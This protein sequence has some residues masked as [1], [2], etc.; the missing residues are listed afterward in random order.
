MIAKWLLGL[1][2]I[3]EVL[4]CETVALGLLGFEGVGFEKQRLF[5]AT[6]RKRSRKVGVRVGIKPYV[7]LRFWS[8][9]H[10]CSRV[11]LY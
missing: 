1:V 3:V 7:R 11:T 6:L 10:Y 5:S 9:Q 8:S 4:G 2:F